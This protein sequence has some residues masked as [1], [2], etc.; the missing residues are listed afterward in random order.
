MDPSSLKKLKVIEL[1]QILKNNGLRVGGT[2]ADLIARILE[3]NIIY[4]NDIK[5]SPVYIQKEMTTKQTIPQLKV[6]LKSYGLKVSGTKAELI[7]RLNAHTGNAGMKNISRTEIKPYEK[8]LVA[9]LKAILKKLKLPVKGLK[10]DL[11]ARLYEYD[12]SREQQEMESMGM[13]DVQSYKT[14]VFPERYEAKREKEREAERAKREAE[15]KKYQE[16]ME[17]I[18]KMSVAEIERQLKISNEKIIEIE[19]KYQQSKIERERQF[20]INTEK[21][22]EVE[23]EYQQKIIERERQGREMEMR[24]VMVQKSELQLEELLDTFPPDIIRR[25]LQSTNKNKITFV[26]QFDIHA[27][28]TYDVSKKMTASLYDVD[29]WIYAFNDGSGN[30]KTI[31]EG[32]RREGTWKLD[33]H[34]IITPDFVK[35][36]IRYHDTDIIA[37]LKSVKKSTPI[38]KFVFDDLE[39]CLYE[40]KR[41]KEEISTGIDGWNIARL[42]YEGR[43]CSIIFKRDSFKKDVQLDKM[44]T[45]EKYHLSYSNIT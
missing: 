26:S 17:P 10:A 18:K 30:M 27:Y 15:L 23:R 19:R 12:K 38:V 41:Y 8:M 2:K 7:E 22:R 21:I 37:K 35:K 33:Y 42:A 1:K 13:E 24:P 32:K 39:E 16:M 3:N 34:R 5:I 43:V 31:R 45:G 36:Y 20:K 9:D 4:E 44:K 14:L 28:H 6:L 11:V 29:G 25:E 40:Y